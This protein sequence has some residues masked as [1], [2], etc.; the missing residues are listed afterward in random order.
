MLF[1]DHRFHEVTTYDNILMLRV[2]MSLY[3][4]NAAHL[5]DF[6][7]RYVA[8]HPKVQHF[9]LVCSSVNMID[10][11]ALETLESLQSRLKGS[12]VTMHLA[13]VKS[14]ILRRLKAV[15]FFEKLEPGRVFL[16]AHDAAEALSSP[17]AEAQPAAP[18]RAEANP[19]PVAEADAPS[20]RSA[21]A[22]TPAPAVQI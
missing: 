12:G 11:S 4:A 7:L 17:V 10:A 8:D 1:R 3:F 6:V 13:A 19:R 16:A 5:E 9:V 18:P 21:V 14:S 22:G 15:G 20:V 2:D